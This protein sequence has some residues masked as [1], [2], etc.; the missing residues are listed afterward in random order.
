MFSGASAMRVFFPN[1]NQAWRT[2]LV[3][4]SLLF[5][6]SCVT[7]EEFLYLNDQIV[8]LNKRVEGLQETTDQAVSKEVISVREQQAK[9]EA[10]LHKIREDMQALSGRLDENNRLVSRAIERD[11]TTQ[12]DMA[13]A[14]AD[15]GD[16]VSRLETVTAQIRAYLNLEPPVS[17]KEA[18]EKRFI[19]PEAEP[20]PQGPAIQPPARPM[21]TPRASSEQEWYNANLALFRNEKYEKAI[22]G[23]KD[24]VKKYPKS[25]L[26]DNAQFWIGES[27][28]G[29]KQYEQ[30]ILAFQKVIKSYPKGNKAANAMLRQAIAFYE[31]NDKIS[32]KLLLKKLIKKYPKSPEAKIAEKKLKTIK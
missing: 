16:R 17:P 6:S 9:A 19:G 11:T 13:G 18:E 24:F 28:M 31:I 32:S 2:A 1:P 3:V 4:F 8:A 15:L 30:A 10:E 12:D 7:D 21:E 20:G 29:L 14:I 5:I 22:A 27:Y 26:A 23:F 25:D